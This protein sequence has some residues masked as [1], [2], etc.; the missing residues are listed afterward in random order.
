MELELLNILLA[1]V[2]VAA[3]IIGA[4]IGLNRNKQVKRI[5]GLGEAGCSIKSQE[6]ILTSLYENCFSLWRGLLAIVTDLFT[7]AMVC[8]ILLMLVF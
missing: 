8:F 3:L 6:A 1:F 7:M 4:P 2:F 5:D